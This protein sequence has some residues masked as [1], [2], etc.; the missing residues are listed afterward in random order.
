ML[1]SFLKVLKLDTHAQQNLPLPG[2]VPFC[3]G[4]NESFGQKCSALSHSAGDWRTGQGPSVVR[5]L[6]SKLV[7]V[8]LK[9]GLS[10]PTLDPLCQNLHFKKLTEASRAYSSRLGCPHQRA[11]LK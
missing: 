9:C 1:V 5:T 7:G 3:R 11:A 8:G 10:G 6:V 2:I 4:E